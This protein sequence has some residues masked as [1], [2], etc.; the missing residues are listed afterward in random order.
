MDTTIF[1]IKFYFIL[2]AFAGCIYQCLTEGLYIAFGV[3]EFESLPSRI[4]KTSN[5][6]ALLFMITTILTLLMI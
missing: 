1:I 4:E 5:V 6:I 3:S 2:F